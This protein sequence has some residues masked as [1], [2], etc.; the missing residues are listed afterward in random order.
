MRKLTIAA[1]LAAA[2]FIAIGG[3][4]G[5]QDASASV[6]VIHGIPE[7]PVDVYVND[8]LTLEDFAPGTVTDA[9]RAP[10]RHLHAGPAGPRCRPGVRPPPDG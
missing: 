4:A 5:A 8:D 1:A 2:S 7:T 3:P 9:D 6:V 10:G